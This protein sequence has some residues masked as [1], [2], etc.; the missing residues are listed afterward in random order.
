MLRRRVDAMRDA[1]ADDPN[2]AAL[3]LAFLDR[4]AISR[5]V[6]AHPSVAAWL[7]RRLT[8]PILAGWQPF[9]RW[10]STPE[11]EADDLIC[12]E[13]L[14]FYIER[15]EPIRNLPDVLD[16]T[17]RLIRDGTGAVRIAGKRDGVALCG[18]A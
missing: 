8:L 16:E 1:V 14:V 13:G 12:E 17:R 10:S 7:R 6:S 11:G 5:W 4:N 18:E 9:G 15:R 2:G 3:D